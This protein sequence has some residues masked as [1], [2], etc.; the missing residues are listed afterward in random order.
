[1]TGMLWTGGH[2]E[3]LTVRCDGEAEAGWNLVWLALD[4]E[5]R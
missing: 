1:M 5:T 2:V 3:I 4:I